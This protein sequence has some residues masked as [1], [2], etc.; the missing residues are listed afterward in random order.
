MIRNL[1]RRLFVFLIGSIAA[2]CAFDVLAGNDRSEVI[3]GTRF[4]EGFVPA[5]GPR[6]THPS[7]RSTHYG[8]G[9]DAAQN[10][11]SHPPLAQNRIGSLA[12]SM[13]RKRFQLENESPR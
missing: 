11:E 3:I 1:D 2:I 7:L 13:E 4:P 12:P 9:L 10:A 5:G 6:V 8:S